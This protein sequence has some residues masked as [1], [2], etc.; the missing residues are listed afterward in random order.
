MI[1]YLAFSFNVCLFYLVF[2]LHIFT[3]TCY[4]YMYMYCIIYFVLGYLLFMFCIHS[5]I[6]QNP[7]FPRTN[8]VFLKWI[9]RTHTKSLQLKNVRMLLCP[10]VQL[11]KEKKTD[12]NLSIVKRDRER[13]VQSVT[14]QSRTLKKCVLWKLF[15]CFSHQRN[16]QTHTNKSVWVEHT[17]LRAEA[18]D[19]I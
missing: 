19:L 7:V 4:V 15:L 14:C 17:V 16:T 2:V 6:E 13:N 9:N 18:F 1:F 10:V 11:K 3:S 8:K 5:K 12:T